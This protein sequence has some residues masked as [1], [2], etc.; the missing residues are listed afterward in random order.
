MSETSAVEIAQT[1]MIPF[2]SDRSG[3]LTAYINARLLAISP[4]PAEMISESSTRCKRF[5]GCG[6]SMRR[7]W[8]GLRGS[9]V[10]VGLLCIVGLLSI[11]GGGHASSSGVNQV[12][13]VTLGT[14]LSTVAVQQVFNGPFLVNSTTGTNLPCELWAFNFTATTGQYLSGGYNSDNSV[15][16][17]VVPQA[18]YQS[19]MT[20]GTCGNSGDALA[21]QLLAT[22]Y[23]F[24]SLAIPSSGTW[25]I[26]IVNASNTTNAGGYLTVYL[27]SSSYTTIYTLTQLSSIQSFTP[28]QSYPAT[29]TLTITSTTTFGQTTTISGFPLV[30]I[31]LGVLGGLVSIV[32]VRRR[33][34]R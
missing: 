15:S 20:A 4:L 6:P 23:N 16:F 8:I 11:V 31:I 17:Y 2:N 9:I 10:V 1:P 22:S 3:V 18:D 34:H 7:G 26:V 5:N 19:W 25:T 32:V 28:T 12:V 33:Q 29:P 24:T 27:S 13:T 14:S 30:S 21:S